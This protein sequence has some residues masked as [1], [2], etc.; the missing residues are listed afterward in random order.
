MAPTI[1]VLN[2]PNLNL[3]GTREPE[4]YGADTLAEIMDDLRAHGKERGVEVVDYQSNVEGELVDRLHQAR[5]VRWLGW[6]SILARSP[7]TASRSATPSRPSSC[8]WWKPTCRTST[9]GRSSD[10]RRCWRPSASGWWPDSDADSYVVALDAL[11]RHVG[12]DAEATGR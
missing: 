1:L 2:G 6:C 4:V 8:R 9:P 12:T 11:I 3:L 7:T 5:R 10:T